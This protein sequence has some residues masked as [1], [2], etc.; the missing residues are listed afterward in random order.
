[1]TSATAMPRVNQE[2]PDQLEGRVGA[3]AEAARFGLPSWTR[4]FLRHPGLAQAGE[5]R[6]LEQ[7]AGLGRQ[8]PPYPALDLRDARIRTFTSQPSGFGEFARGAVQVAAEGIGGGEFDAYER[9]GRTGAAA[10]FE[11]D[12]RLIG[13][14]LEQMHHP[15]R[16][17][18]STDLG[19]AGAE[20]DGLLH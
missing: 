17:V 18:P 6:G 16:A 5:I 12:D 15:N 19:V 11:P 9:F 2:G 1:M 8:R 7:G 10:S 13:A 14:R 20:A 4:S 3:F